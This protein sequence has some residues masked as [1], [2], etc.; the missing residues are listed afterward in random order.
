[1]RLR[2]E[3]ASTVRSVQKP[4]TYSAIRSSGSV[5]RTM[6]ECKARCAVLQVMECSREWIEYVRVFV[7]LFIA[8]SDDVAERSSYTR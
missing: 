8:R 2:L 1:V 3:L 5:R 6:R 7:G 4:S